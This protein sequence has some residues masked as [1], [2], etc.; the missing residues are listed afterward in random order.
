M[1]A[2][3]NYRAFV[4]TAVH[5]PILG[6]VEYL[7]DV[8]IALS[9]DGSIADISHKDDVQ[10]VLSEFGITEAEVYYMKV[11][12]IIILGC[13]TF[14]RVLLRSCLVLVSSG[15]S[16]KVQGKLSRHRVGYLA[17]FLHVTTPTNAIRLQ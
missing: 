9:A 2:S 11:G 5:F 14:S 3:Q 13:S 8:C 4:G 10:L 12:N 17:R 16:I 15:A 1:T 7:E 6:A